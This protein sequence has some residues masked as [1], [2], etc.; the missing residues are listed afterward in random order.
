MDGLITLIIIFGIISRIS[1]KSKQKQEAVNKARRKAEAFAEAAAVEAMKGAKRAVKSVPEPVKKAAEP[2][3][4][5]VEKELPFTK[6][7]WAEFVAR[8]KAAPQPSA[9][10][11]TGRTQVMPEGFSPELKSTQGES[12]AEHR[13]H[14]EKIAAEEKQRHEA[15]LAE[16]NLR[17]MN[18]KKLRQAVIMSEV[19]GKPVAL[20]GRRI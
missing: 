14:A 8:K 18:L 6:E 13:R 16:E 10:G 11:S 7:E 4:R 17:S 19:L 1:K 3:V 9:E 5:T 12:A 2:I 15:R 20:R